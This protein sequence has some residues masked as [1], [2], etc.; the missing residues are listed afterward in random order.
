M[1][2]WL[3]KSEPDVYSWDDLEKEGQAEWDGV[4]NYQARNMMRDEMKMNDLVLFYHSNTKPH[5]HIAGIAKVC[6]EGYPDFTSWDKKSKYY[7]SKSTKENPRWFMVDVKPIERLENIVTL[8]DVKEKPELSS[9][10]LIKRGQR[11]SIQRVT[12]DEYEIIREMGGLP[13]SQIKKE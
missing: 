6:R 10:A 13:E 2:I 11:L 9:M 7:D 3:M 12:L 1:K 5:P 4:R 8:Q